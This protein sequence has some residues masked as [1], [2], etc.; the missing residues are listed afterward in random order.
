[1]WSREMKYHKAGLREKGCD[2]GMQGPYKKYNRV[3]LLIIPDPP[4]VN[5]STHAIARSS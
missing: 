3:V 5:S 2:R 1:M 4:Y